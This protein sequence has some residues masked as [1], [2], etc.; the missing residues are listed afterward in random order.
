MVNLFSRLYTLLT[1]PRDTENGGEVS[2][3]PR[4]LELHTLMKQRDALLAEQGRNFET[5]GN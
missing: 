2:E 5:D 4:K 3:T 1:D